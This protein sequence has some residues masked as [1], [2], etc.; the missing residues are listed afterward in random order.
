M[1]GRPH[2][3]GQAPVLL[4]N[5]MHWD[6]EEEEEEDDAR[7][8]HAPGPLVGAPRRLPGRA[9]AGGT[10]RGSGRNPA[11]HAMAMAMDGV[12]GDD[13]VDGVVGSVTGIPTT[14]C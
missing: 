13:G 3:P 6:E 4:M 12:V 8:V 11:G 10:P 1:R 9:A 5:S 7:P 2:A 14:E